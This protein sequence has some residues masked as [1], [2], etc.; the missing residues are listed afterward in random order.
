MARRLLAATPAGSLAYSRALLTLGWCLMVREKLEEAATTLA[1]AREALAAAGVRAGA[2]R[3][4]HG[5]LLVELLRQVSADLL[6]LWAELAESY[7]AEGLATEAVRV[8]VG[9]VRCLIILCRGKE[10]LELGRAIQ[11]AVEELGA[12]QDRALLSRM[13]GVAHTQLGNIPEAA[14]AA[15]E[16]GFRR[17]R[18]P[19]ELARTWAEQANLALRR[20]DFHAARALY[21]RASQAFG[22]LDMPL[23]VAYMMK[24]LG[25]TATRLGQ[26]DRAFAHLVATRASFAS[27]N[28]PLNVAEC[29][30][31]L[32][33]AA[34]YSGLFELALASWRQTEAEYTRL[35]MPQLALTS[36]RNQAEALFRLGHHEAA[37]EILAALIPVA[38]QLDA[39]SDLGE[40]FHVLGEVRHAQGD[41][42]QARSALLQAEQLFAELPN[43]P[44]AAR[45]RLAQGRL[46]LS[47]GALTEAE[48]QF[49]HALCG[50]DASPIYRWRAIHGLGR[51]AELNGAPAAALEH[52]REAC[53]E[54]ARLRNR[55]AEAHASSALF[56]EART[57][58]DDTISLAARQGEALIVLQVAEQQRAMALQQQLR[59]ESFILPPAL[60]ATHER[61]RARLRD[62][63]LSK[64]PGPDL[65]T[66]LTQYLELLLHS[67]HATLP[68]APEE[69]PE[70]NLDL[71]A[72]RAALGARHGDAWTALVYVSFAGRLAVLTVTPTQIHLHALPSD[73]ELRQ[74][75]ERACLPR[76][77]AFTYRDL[78]FH[79]GQRTERWADLAALGA[80]LIPPEAAARL[81]PGHRLLIVPGGPLH[82]LPWAALRVGGQWLVER[83]V[84]QLAPSLRL[85]AELAARPR[86]GRDALLVGVGQFGGRAADL[87]SA[88]PS[89]DLAAR[90]W[91]GATRRLENRAVTRAA[92]RMLGA[93]GGVRPFGLVHLA[94]HGQL[95]G[96]RGALAHLKL[97]DDDLFADEL[98]QLQLS[99][100]L[101]VLAACEGALGET[102][103]GEEQVSLGW[104]LLAGGARDV[105]ASLW[106][107]YDLTTLQIL[108]V[109]YAAVAAG[110]DAASALAHAQR[111]CI[112]V[113][114]ER[115]DEPLGMPFIWASLC[116]TGAGVN[117]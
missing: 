109:F 23:R 74:R 95:S 25:Y 115:P 85:W 108:E 43:R 10:A 116:A 35:G 2:L 77:R 34:F 36:R 44:A 41:V 93:D 19:G 51:C 7:D 26:L 114:R 84:I 63:A 75:L 96:G 117:G 52:Y 40:I 76:Y 65:E 66:A 3:A 67:R 62:A 5:E 18:L 59:R 17:L 8:R 16:A 56:R 100:A 60:H 54:V 105:V 87:P 104:A 1:R 78:P 49:R 20:E 27:L 80:R 58:V 32:G 37:A 112:G 14:L 79:N 11:P 45:A 21:E 89:L 57:L 13:L 42:S 4:R 70:H 91:P 53:A 111:A 64:V 82:S 39:R 83:A 24:N 28:Q 101:V 113:G 106:Q 46:A 48:T 103:P 61:R 55:L 73:Q 71:A 22:R 38:E 92:L 33:I 47:V 68:A 110:H 90:Y 69:T 107:L 102:L 9:H 50:L 30:L 31:H 97:A 15:A 98:A 99:G 6:P 88:I 12:A 29:T 81:A 94:T 72:L 86:A